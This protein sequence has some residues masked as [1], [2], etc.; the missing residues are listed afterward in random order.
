MLSDGSFEFNIELNSWYAFL[1]A[2]LVIVI[3]ADI[4]VHP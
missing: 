1:H 2:D 3:D 4:V